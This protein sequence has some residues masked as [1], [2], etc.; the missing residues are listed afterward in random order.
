MVTTDAYHWVFFDY[1]RGWLGVRIEPEDRER[2]DAIKSLIPEED[3]MY[4]RDQR[5]WIFR[6]KYAPQMIEIIRAYCEDFQI[7]LETQHWELIQ[8]LLL[9]STKLTESETITR[10]EYVVTPPIGKIL[11]SSENLSGKR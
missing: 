11:G 3:R 1:K 7:I 10:S 2:V 9:G 4:L 5:K 8:S 6:P